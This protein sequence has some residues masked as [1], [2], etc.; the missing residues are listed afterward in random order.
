MQS[1]T[2]QSAYLRPDK[3]HALSLSYGAFHHRLAQYLRRML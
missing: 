2:G 3:G 1:I